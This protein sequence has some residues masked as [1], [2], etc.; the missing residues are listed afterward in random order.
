MAIKKQQPEKQYIM[1][2]PEGDLIALGNWEEVR[3][4]LLEF[5]S[6]SDKDDEVPFNE[7]ITQITIHEL[8]VGK[9]IKYTPSRFE[10]K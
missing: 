1:I 3:H 7:W 8:G 4:A 2:D 6:D 5:E 9:K 10:L